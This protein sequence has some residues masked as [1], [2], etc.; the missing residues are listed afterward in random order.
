[1]EE[2]EFKKKFGEAVKR[3]NYAV[4][5]FGLITLYPEQYVLYADGSVTF[6]VKELEVAIGNLRDIKEVS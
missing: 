4:V 1:M 2:A 6:H 5:D 3:D